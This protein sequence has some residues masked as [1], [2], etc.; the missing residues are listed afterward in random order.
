MKQSEEERL[1]KR[2]KMGYA[3]PPVAAEFKE[4]KQIKDFA[5]MEEFVAYMLNKLVADW[6]ATTK[7]DGAVR[8]REFEEAEM[9]SRRKRVEAVLDAMP[10][11]Y[12]L[13]QDSS[14]SHGVKTSIEGIA[15]ALLDRDYTEAFTAHRTLTETVWTT[16]GK[17]V[18][19]SK[20]ERYL[21][22]LKL[23][24]EFGL[25]RYPNARKHKNNYQS[26]SNQDTQD[27]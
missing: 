26:V 7:M 6:Y 4:W 18:E 21:G 2:A 1:L 25:K 5:T 8:L 14:L 23:L 20:K 16:G 10:G 12:A 9:L 11:L 13:L 24:I 22:N 19:E 17:P 27:F 3:A 15:E